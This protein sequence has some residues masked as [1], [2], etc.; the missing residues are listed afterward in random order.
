MLEP[1]RLRLATLFAA[2]ALAV[3]ACPRPASAQQQVDPFGDCCIASVVMTAYNAWT[4][5]C[6]SCSANPGQYPLTQPDPAKLVYVGPGGVSA[7]SPYDA[8]LAVCKCPS[9]D[10]RRA[11]EKQMRTFDGN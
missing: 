4:I 3:C 7:N 6:G 10:A 11:R 8:A 1:V 2:I 5:H 9:Q